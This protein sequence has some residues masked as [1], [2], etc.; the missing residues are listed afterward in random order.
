MIWKKKRRDGQGDQ[1]NCPTYL[2][3]DRDGSLCVSDDIND[4]VMKWVVGDKEGI[5]VTD[6]NGRDDSLIQW[7]RPAEMIVDQLRHVYTTDFGND[8]VMH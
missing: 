2:F 5:V 7:P 8:R 3:V 4:R 6:E 1:L